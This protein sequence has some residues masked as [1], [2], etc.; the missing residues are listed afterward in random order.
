MKNLKRALSFA[1]ATVMLIGMMVV[2][3]S[4]ADFS[5]A[6]EIVN[7]VAVETLVALNV[8][9][10]KDDGSYDPT[11]NVTRAEMA[12]LI[13]VALN[14]GK[15]PVLGTKATPSYTDIKGHWAESYIEYCSN[16]G[17]VSGRGD[18]T[19]DPN[20]TVTGSEAAKMMLVAMGYETDIFGF[21][22]AAWAINVNTEANKASLYEDIETID[23]SAA[24]NRDNT[25]QLVF[26]GIMAPTM[27]K[28]PNMTVT[29]G[30]IT[31]VYQPAGSLFSTKFNGND[32]NTGVL[33]SVSYN[34]VKDYYVHTL[35]TGATCT[36]E[37]DY[38]NLMG[39]TVTLLNNNDANKLDYGMYIEDGSI[40]ATAYASQITAMSTADKTIK[41]AGTTYDLDAASI[42]VR[43]YNV[44]GTTTATAYTAINGNGNIATLIDNDGDDKVDAVVL[45]PFTVGKIT[46]VGNDTFTF[47][48][49][50]VK[51]DDVVLYDG[52]A[53]GDVAV[54]TAAAQTTGTKDVYVN[55][56]YTT[57]TVSGQNKD[58]KF[59]IDGAWYKNSSG[60]SIAINDTVK[61]VAFGGVI[62]AAEVVE[63]SAGTDNLAM[64]YRAKDKDAV[65][66]GSACVEIKLITADGT[67]STGTLAKINGADVLTDD[68][69]VGTADYVGGSVT[70]AP[71]ALIGQIVYY[72]INSDGEYEVKTIPASYNT[73]KVLGYNGTG[74][75]GEGYV[76]AT[77][78]FGTHELAD[79]AVVFYLHGN[80]GVDNVNN[81]AKVYTGKQVKNTQSNLPNGVATFANSLY[82]TTNGY[83]YTQVAA[84]NSAS[85]AATPVWLGIV[86]GTNYGYLTAAPYTTKEGSDTY[87]NYTMWTANGKLVAKEKKAQTLANFPAGTIVTYDVKSEGVVENVTIENAATSYVTG[88]DGDKKVA[89]AGATSGKIGDE[90]VILYV[91]TADNAGV[92]GGVISIADEPT[93]GNY[94]NN[95]RYINGG[96]EYA[97]IVVDVNNKYEGATS[98]TGSVTAAAVNSAI[99]SGNVRITGDFNASA[100]LV[101]PAGKTVTIVGAVTADN[102]ADVA[103][104]M[105]AA[106]G[107]VEADKPAV[108]MSS[109]TV[110]G[111]GDIA[112][113]LSGATSTS[114][115]IYK[116]DLSKITGVT[117]SSKVK[118]N[119]NAEQALDSDVSYELIVGNKT[120][121]ATFSIAKD[122]NFSNTT[123]GN[124]VTMTIEFPGW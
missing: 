29:N 68:D 107:T 96:T 47:A 123:A 122:G 11:G 4:A 21:T 75:A 38:S 90:T 63:A 114:A 92:E 104:A 3:V 67:K 69:A 80:D 89:I 15:T 106:V 44:T 26:N 32:N 74:A 5:D 85:V 112:S 73:T 48:G 1:L 14:G 46:Y 49:G 41:M 53:K 61:F 37:K 12:K 87:T 110:T 57:G 102:V 28:S 101:V 25:A 113:L 59:Q 42:T 8:I 82:K 109:G 52:A 34:A 58:G 93:S 62:Y 22:G 98:L 100:G 116:I 16:L 7:A 108:V 88:F 13:T 27:T 120:E 55:V 77:E 70:A 39:T 31:W 111:M 19:F 91:N 10:G 95:V 20:G 43:T 66:T 40:V 115:A 76:T 118:L 23:P 51:K 121:S 30:E 117:S 45:K 97:L 24:L 6:D 60:T 103:R 71:Q 99:K 124:I 78:K 35:D 56:E 9:D 94:V 79:D 17:I 86:T 81:N 83:T 36:T 50:S 105:D 54:K 72:E 2:G 119:A 18:G 84:L 65:G 64:I 33:V